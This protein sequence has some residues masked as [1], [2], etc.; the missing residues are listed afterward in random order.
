[1]DEYIKYYNNDRSR[2]NLIKMSS[3]Q[4]RTHYYQNQL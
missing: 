1:M 4:Y 2:S 3:I